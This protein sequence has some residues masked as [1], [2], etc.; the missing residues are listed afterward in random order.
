M[1]RQNEYHYAFIKFGE[2]KSQ[3]AKRK[4]LEYH[5]ISKNDREKYGIPQEIKCWI[6][7]KA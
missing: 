4:G 2:R 3:K 6:I 7:T 1:H 5:Q